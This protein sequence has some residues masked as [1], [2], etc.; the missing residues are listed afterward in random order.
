VYWVVEVE[1]ES[2]RP[3]HLTV[4]REN[5]FV[6]AYRAGGKPVHVRLDDLPRVYQVA[7]NP[8]LAHVGNGK[9]EGWPQIRPPKLPKR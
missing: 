9:P 7:L 1:M 8:V 2:V 5:P 4:P 3:R 6:T